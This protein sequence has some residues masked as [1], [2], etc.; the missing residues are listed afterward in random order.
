MWGRSCLDGG[1]TL[2][3]AGRD[4]IEKFYTGAADG[5]FTMEAGTAKACAGVV[6][7]L[8]DGLNA[9]RAVHRYSERVSFGEFES[10]IQM[11][12]GFDRKDEEYRKILYEFVE[13]ANRLKLSFEIAGARVFE[14]EADN[15]AEVRRTE[16]G[17]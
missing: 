17:R 15:T 5:V 2:T 9:E 11:Q 7:T 16:G 12:A 1:L 8:I 6:Q 14:A 10:S 13:A 3:I 4:E